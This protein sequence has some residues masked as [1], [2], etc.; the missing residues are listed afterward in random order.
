MADIRGWPR[1]PSAGSSADICTSSLSGW[2]RSDEYRRVLPLVVIALL[3]TRAGASDVALAR[4]SCVGLTSLTIPDVT[5]TSA[6]EVPAGPFNPGGGARGGSMVPA[7]CRV[8]AVA[9]PSA[10]SNINLEIWIP[11]IAWNGKLLGTANGGFAGAIPYGPMVSGLVKR[12]ATVGTDTGHTGDQMEFG[13]GHPEKIIDWGFRAVHVMTETAKIVVRSE[14]GRFPDRSYFDG[15]STGGQQGLSEAQRYPADYDG[16]V[17]GDPGHNRVRLILGFLWGW[18]AMHGDDGKPVLSAAKLATITKAAVTACDAIDGVRDGLIDDPSACRF[19]PATLLCKGADENT[20][21][22]EPQVAA[23]RKVYDGAKNPRT[24]AQIFPGW[25][26]GSE[27]G[28]GAYLLNPSEP[29]RVGFFRS[30]RSEG[31][32]N[33]TADRSDRSRR[34]RPARADRPDGRNAPGDREW[35]HPARDSGVRVSGA[36]GH[37]LRRGRGGRRESFYGR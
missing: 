20:C 22:T 14:R 37:R 16:I 12:Y 30:I 17:A 19:D 4:A 18:M 10:D 34:R 29:S 21:L 6:T 26:R 3:A 28:W 33:R 35:I 13:L 5:I 8:V 15:C 27:Q 1:R 23:V 7:F 9:R 25:A 32:R 2:A 36:G 11:T 24:H 31:L